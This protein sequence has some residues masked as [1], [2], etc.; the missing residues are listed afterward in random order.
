MNPNEQKIFDLRTELA[1]TSDDHERVALLNQI[2]FL[3]RIADTPL[4]IA[5]AQES[6]QLAGKIGDDAGVAGAHLS[7][8]FG[9]YMLAKFDLAQEHIVK[10]LYLFERLE[11][12][13]SAARA[14]MAM[15][16]THWSTGNFDLALTNAFAGMK[17]LEAEDDEFTGWGWNIMGGIHQSIGD[18]DKAVEYFDK[19]LTAFEKIGSILGQ[20]RVMNGMAVALESIGDF[21]ESLK[22]SQKALDMHRAGGNPLGEARALNDMGSAYFRM[23]RLDEAKMHHEQSLALR[24]SISNRASEITSLLNLGIVHTALREFAKAHTHLLTALEL[25]QEIGAKPKIYEIH[26]ALSDSFERAGQ[27]EKAFEHYKRFHDLKEEVLSNETSTRLRH[28]Q[29]NLATEKAERDTEIERLKNHE[30]A[31]ANAEIER[32]MAILDEQAT[33]IEIANAVLEEQNMTI[34]QMHQESERLLLNVLPNAI[35]KRLKQGEKIIADSFE[36]VTVL[37]ADIVGFTQLSARTSPPELVEMLD[38]IFSDFDALA[39]KYGLEK[40]K[41]IG[42]C[43]MV[44]GGVPLPRADHAHAVSRMALEMQGAIKRLSDATNA[45]LRIRIGIHTG[46]VV[47]GVIGKKKFS[48]D[49][50]GDTVNTASRMESHGEPDTVH[51][52][53]AVFELLKNDFACQERGEQEIKG[54][55]RMKTYFLTS[56]R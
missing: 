25:A 29:T 23:Q 52:S 42:D 43:Y 26:H 3:S 24:R 35:A 18:V 48:Y 12:S 51:I 10:A 28:L 11:D 15:A 49:L 14:R 19:S 37:F 30:L 17:V 13:T 22:F 55:G 36:N 47:A 8:G 38:A 41:T 44:V 5:T 6:L 33:N 45:N 4:A 34:A 40:I 39:E 16:A 2:A 32:Q 31:E 1:S 9:Q 7:L 54:K 27:I 53:Q 56:R 21:E 50:W 20:A 46:A